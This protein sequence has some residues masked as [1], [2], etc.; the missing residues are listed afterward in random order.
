MGEGDRRRRVVPHQGEECDPGH[1]RATP[2][3]C[4]RRRTNSPFAAF[5]VAVESLA[6]RCPRAAAAT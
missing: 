1:G 5:A 4:V 2:P 6:A 3:T